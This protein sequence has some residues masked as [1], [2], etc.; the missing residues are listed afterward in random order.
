MQTALYL[1]FIDECGIVEYKFNIA[2][3]VW[4]LNGKN[5]YLLEVLI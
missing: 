5:S 1:I 4:V 3:H 2:D